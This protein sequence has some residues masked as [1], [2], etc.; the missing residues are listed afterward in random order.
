MDADI[1]SRM[2]GGAGS[3]S[4]PT[5]SSPRPKAKSKRSTHEAKESIREEDIQDEISLPSAFLEF[6]G[7]TD[8][9]N[10]IASHFWSAS[11]FMPGHETLRKYEAIEHMTQYIPSSLSSISAI[12]D[13]Q[14]EIQALE[15]FKNNLKEVEWAEAVDEE[16][17][18]RKLCRT[19]REVASIAFDIAGLVRNGDSWGDDKNEQSIQEEDRSQSPKSSRDRKLVKK[20]KK[21]SRKKR[22]RASRQPHPVV[23]RLTF[24]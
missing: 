3:H 4:T 6:K 13:F 19:F 2:L 15:E 16:S 20:I 21:A 22:K 17:T 9:R 24:V 8:N 11:S 5:H 1:A 18:K 7:D 14:D 12:T 10:D 23:H